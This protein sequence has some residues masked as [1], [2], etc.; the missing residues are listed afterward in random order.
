MKID[1]KKVF[2][3]N[4]TID[5]LNKIY[6]WSNDIEL[7]E[8]ECDNIDSIQRNK[9][10]NDFKN[11]IMIP[12][13]IGKNHESNSSM[14]YFGIYRHYN[15]ELIG[16]VV[17][18]YINE[19]DA[20]LSLSICERAYRNKHYGIDATIIALKYAFE[21]KKIK[22]IIIQTRIDNGI[23]KN[24]CRKIGLHYEIEHFKDDNYDID[25]VKYVIN[26]DIYEKILSNFFK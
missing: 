4:F 24:I 1:G 25:L 14:C 16:T 11:N 17:F 10:I 8:I 19:S 23:V 2:L 3:N 12:C 20:E 18:Q 5:D 21:I 26:N 13:F 6:E 7:I 15:N 9:N 22:N